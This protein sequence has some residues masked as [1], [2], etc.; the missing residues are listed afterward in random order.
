[1]QAYEAKHSTNGTQREPAA[2]PSESTRWDM[3]IH[4]VLGITL[5]ATVSILGCW[6]VPQMKDVTSELRKVREAEAKKSEADKEMA[7]QIEAAQ[8]RNAI[9]TAVMA[10]QTK[11]IREN[12][13]EIERQSN[14]KGKP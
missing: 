14:K 10:E 9:R 3:M 13:E 7:R 5:L 2:R 6:I 4:L 8:E 12:M 11:R 1:M